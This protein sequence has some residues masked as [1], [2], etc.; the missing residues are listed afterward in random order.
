MRTYRIS[1]L[2]VVLA[3]LSSL[4]LL[5]PA[6]SSAVQYKVDPAHTAVTFQVRHLFSKVNGRFD[7]FAGKIDFDP[8]QP[9]KT[10]VEGSIDVASINTN[11]EKRD[12][13]LRSKDFF[14]VEKYPQITFASTG[15]SDVDMA[16]K[17]GKLHGNLTIRGVEKPV[18]LD[19]VFLGAG[20]DPWGNVRAG[21]TAKTTINRKDYGL[22]WNE[23]LETG[24]VL[25]GDGIDI[26]IDAEGL[27]ED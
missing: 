8:A 11:E 23:T 5:S 15:V 22:T 25:V 17:T 19:V 4:L 20:K 26:E 18:V 3:T 24:G 14:Q 16:K 27:V 2:I 10:R 7:K 6:V 21:F 13:H 1:S 12:K 9:E